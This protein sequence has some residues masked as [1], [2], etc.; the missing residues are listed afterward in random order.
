MAFPTIAPLQ[1]MALNCSRSCIVVMPPLAVSRTGTVCKI[2]AYSWTEGPFSIPSCSISVQITWFMPCSA[3]WR[4]KA[5]TSSSESR[6]Q[7]CV[8]TFRFRQSAPSIRR[9]APKRSSQEHTNCGFSTAILPNVTRSA[10]QSKAFSRSVS[11][12]IP[13]PKSIFRRVFAAIRPVVH[14]LQPVLSGLHPGQPGAGIAILQASISSATSNG[15]ALY[16]VLRL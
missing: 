4:I 11:V 6:S 7:P 14:H 2:S 15:S 13:P 3:Y 9:S 10:P 5:V 1:P 12:R 16:T 8:A